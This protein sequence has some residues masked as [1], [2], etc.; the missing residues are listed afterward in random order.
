MRL[1]NPQPGF[2]KRAVTFSLENFTV[3][4][5]KPMVVGKIVGPGGPLAATVR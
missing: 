1:L 5:D 4:L 3:V 2:P